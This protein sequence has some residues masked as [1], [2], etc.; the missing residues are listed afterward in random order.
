MKK[1]E[2]VFSFRF[3]DL[4][5]EWDYKKNDLIP[6][7]VSYGSHKEVWWKCKKCNHNWKTQVKTRSCGHGCP[8]CGKISNAKKNS[9]KNIKTNCFSKKHPELCCEWSENNS[10]CPDN[11]SAGSHKIV[12]W[13]CKKCG[14]E[15]EAEIKNRSSGEGCPCCSGKIVSKFNRLTIKNPEICCDWD[16]EKN[17][18]VPEN[19][20]YKSSKIV[21]WKCKKCN[22][23]WESIIYNRSNGR[24]CP[25][26]SGR[27]VTKSNCLESLNLKLCEEWNY[28]KNDLTPRDVHHASSKIVWWKCKKCNHE[29]KFSVRSKKYGNCPKCNNNNVSN[30]ETEWLNSLNIPEK[31]RQK[32]IKVSGR[33]Y[34]V[35]GYD[36]K[37][38]TVYEFNGDFWHGNPDKFNPDDINPKNKKK[39]G[40]LYKET[41][42]KAE[43]LK[44]AGYKIISIWG[45][46]FQS[47]ENT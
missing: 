24:G 42:I 34:K 32:V 7:N 23:E 16:Y 13:K 20:S 11:F 35:D 21:W 27:V 28:E 45:G 36:P 29:W 1:K 5:E 25:G 8:I 40:D 19:V 10:L 31:N 2:N 37:T 47:K 9:L 17:D 46:E 15:W 22:H 33:K 12:W 30:Q 43:I 26:C 44:N 39:Y 18:L 6:E 41:I 38:K 14:H 3:P 4:C